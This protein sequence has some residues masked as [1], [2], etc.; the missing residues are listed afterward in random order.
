MATA[1]ATTSRVLNP[2]L[3][4]KIM[5]ADEAAGLIRSGDQVGMSGDFKSPVW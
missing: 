5:S 2:K 3:V 1:V 4:Q